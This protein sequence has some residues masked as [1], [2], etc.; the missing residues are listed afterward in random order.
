MLIRELD[1]TYDIFIAST[2][3]TRNKATVIG[4]GFLVL[5][6]DILP[7]RMQRT[8]L[9]KGR[10]NSKEEELALPWEMKKKRESKHLDFFQLR[11]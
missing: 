7:L 11:C 9:R 1:H 2:G 5:W 8:D 3:L 4:K 10:D 6:G